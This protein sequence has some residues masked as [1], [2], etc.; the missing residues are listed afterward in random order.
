M[1]SFPSRQS[2]SHCY[3]ENFGLL[4]ARRREALADYSF[5]ILEEQGFL[6]AD[7]ALYPA[8]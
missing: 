8:A 4:I 6:E 7:G 1:L 5:K 3:R 2:I